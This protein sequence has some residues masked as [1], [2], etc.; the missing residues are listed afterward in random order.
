MA[1]VGLG[2][3]LLPQFAGAL[4]AGVGWRWAYAGLRVALLVIV[5]PVHLFLIRESARRHVPTAAAEDGPTAAQA[6]RTRP[7]SSRCS[8]TAGL[9]PA[10]RPA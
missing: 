9:H 10:R 3:A 1:G 2:T 7:T 5:V 6:V 4:I 8:S